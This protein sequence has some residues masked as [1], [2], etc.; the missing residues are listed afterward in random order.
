MRNP[1]Q[2]LVYQIER[3]Q[4]HKLT[5]FDFLIK[6]LINEEMQRSKHSIIWSTLNELNKSVA[7]GLYFYKL[8]SG[9]DVVTQKMM[10]LK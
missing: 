3:V 9:K 5:Q 2:L 1:T 8:S 10:L 4:L 6:N 7:S